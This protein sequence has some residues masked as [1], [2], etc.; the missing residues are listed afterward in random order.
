[1]GWFSHPGHNRFGTCLRGIA[2][3]A[4]KIVLML[5]FPDDEV[6]NHLVDLDKL[7]ERGINPRSDVLSLKQFRNNSEIPNTFTGV[8]YIDYYQSCEAGRSA[9]LF[10]QTI[11]I[12]GAYKSVLTCDITQSKSKANFVMGG[13]GLRAG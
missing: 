4:K 1:M 11:P 2:M 8:D 6:G 7:D 13:K 12:N 10:S 3:G 5:S 9:R